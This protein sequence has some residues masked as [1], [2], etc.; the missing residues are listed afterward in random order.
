MRKTL[1]L[2]FLST[3]LVA[4]VVAFVGCGDSGTMNN[5]LVDMAMQQGQGDMAMNN[6]N[7]PDMAFVCFSGTP[8]TNSDFLNACTSSASEDVMPFWPTLAP[9]GQLPSLP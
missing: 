3:A 4:S 8:M 6:G 2:G 7:N 1:V 9:N 5:N